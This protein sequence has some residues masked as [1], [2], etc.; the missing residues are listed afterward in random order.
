MIVDDSET[1]DIAPAQALGM[2]TIRVAIEAPR[3]S[4]SA[5]DHVCTSL[6][7]VADILANGPAGRF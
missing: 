1:N 4:T 2:G 3:P 6:D 5:A 7:E